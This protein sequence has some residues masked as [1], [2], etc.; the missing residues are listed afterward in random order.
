MAVSVVNAGKHISNNPLL[1]LPQEMQSYNLVGHHF[2]RCYAKTHLSI[3]CIHLDTN[4]HSME[5]MNTPFY[6]CSGIESTPRTVNHG[7]PESPIENHGSC[8]HGPRALSGS[9]ES[10]LF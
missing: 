4:T 7:E 9:Q 3:G 2:V 6:F 5:T 10:L 1:W 8:T